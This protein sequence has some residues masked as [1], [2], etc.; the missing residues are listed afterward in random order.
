MDD[1]DISSETEGPATPPAPTP[2][3]TPAHRTPMDQT[4]DAAKRVLAMITGR[5]KH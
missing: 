3:D 5:T 4:R 1:V 2:A